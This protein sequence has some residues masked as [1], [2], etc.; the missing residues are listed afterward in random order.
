MIELQGTFYRLKETEND[1]ARPFVPDFPYVT[2]KLSDSREILA[3][4]DEHFPY[5]LTTIKIEPTGLL[6][7]TEEFI[8]ISNNESFPNGFFRILPKYNYSRNGDRRRTDITLESVTVNGEEKP[9]HMTEI[10]NYLHIEP[11]EPLNRRP[12]FIHIVS[13]T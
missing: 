12:E 4:A 1:E 6:R 8:F 13:N 11:D 3:P 9:Y 7:V 5:V 10:G 2:V